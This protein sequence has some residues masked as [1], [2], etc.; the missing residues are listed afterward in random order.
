VSDRMVYIILRSSGRDIVILNVHAPAK[1]E[2][3]NIAGSRR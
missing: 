1:D 3:C 2:N